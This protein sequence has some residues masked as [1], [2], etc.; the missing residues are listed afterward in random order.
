MYI[1]NYL[2]YNNFTIETIHIA[3]D[4]CSAT[5][6]LIEN[7]VS[8]VITKDGEKNSKI[9]HG[10][11]P[12][13]SGIFTGHFL[14]QLDESGTVIE[15]YHKEQKISKGY[16]TTSVEPIVKKLG[17]YC[18]SEYFDSLPKEAVKTCRPT[19]FKPK[20]GDMKLKRE[21]DTIIADLKDFQTKDKGDVK[22]KKYR[23]SDF[24]KKTTSDSKTEMDQET[25]IVVKPKTE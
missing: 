10:D 12:D 5:E 9:L 1:V 16:L 20:V 11:D 21:W 22:I 7:A 2:D 6:F 3:K 19:V 15:L 8:N 18:I 23:R 17:R 25:V 4:K 24:I 13:H 14:H